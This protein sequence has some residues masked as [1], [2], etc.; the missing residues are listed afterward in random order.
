MKNFILGALCAI[1]LAPLALAAYLGFGFMD[2]AAD[3]KPSSLEASLMT[4]AVRASVRRHAP[5]ERSPLPDSDAT[6]IAGGKLYLNDC[7][8]C[9]G[10]PGQPP[11]TFGLSFYP[12]AP[13]FPRAG[14]Q[15]S[16]AE[17]YWVAKHGIRMTGMYPQS[18]YADADLW[19]LTRFISHVRNLPPAIAKA[20]QPPP[21]G[22]GR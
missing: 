8:G 17:I 12:P 7:V 14:T 18:H 11:S 20:I 1:A 4:A 5:A 10:E 22:D 19:R 16:E 15:Y 6:L 2:V 9:H 3:A 21:S 13:Q